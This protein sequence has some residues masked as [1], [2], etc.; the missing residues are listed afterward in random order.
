MESNR[1]FAIVSV[2]VVSVVLAVLG[3][4]ATYVSQTGMANISAEVKYQV[5]EKNAN[6]GLM[7]A[8]KELID[9]TLNCGDTKTYSTDKGSVRVVT[10]SGGNSCFVWAEGR[11]SGGRVVKV[12]II[13]LGGGS[14]FGALSFVNFEGSTMKLRNGSVIT[15]NGFECSALTYVD[16]G[17]VCDDINDYT[18]CGSQPSW[19]GCIDGDVY[20][21]DNIDPDKLFLKMALDEI[22]ADIKNR[23]EKKFNEVKDSIPTKPVVSDTNCV[24]ENVSSCKIKWDQENVIECGGVT[25][26]TSQCPDGIVIR[27]NSVSLD[28]WKGQIYAPIIIEADR[29]EKIRLG[30]TSIRGS[31]FI[32][33]TSLDCGGNDCTIIEMNNTSSLTG[34]VV[35]KADRM[36]EYLKLANESKIDGNI[37]IDLDPTITGDENEVEIK[38]SNNSQITGNV[39]FNGYEFEID[40]ANDTSVGGDIVAKGSHEVEIEMS[41]NSSIKGTIYAYGIDEFELDASNATSIGGKGNIMITDKEFELEINNNTTQDVGILA[42]VG[43]NLSESEAE[44]E[45]T[46]KAF[47]RGFILFG[48]MEELKLPNESMIEGVILGYNLT[49]ELKLSNSANIKGML[50]VL[51]E[52]GNID[53]SNKTEIVGLVY[54]K[55]L[56]KVDMTNEAN[57]K[58]NIDLINKLISDFNLADYFKTLKCEGQKMKVVE[59]FKMKVY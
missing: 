42:W 36:R 11:Y 32:E 41:N 13:G 55:L 6:Y 29:V 1:G 22:K 16:C 50:L 18:G 56:D 53:M 27:G 44:I 4:T 48:N 39:F 34:D 28:F 15:N 19:K 20:N 5:A 59:M 31:M 12:N 51:N 58:L 14:E 23:F 25:L 7:L 49:D 30:E 17:S 10:K 46:N 21:P 35:I 47:F 54:A 3:A 43:D 45:I 26:D 52:L 57:I 24:L 33:A 37:Y 9:K 38:L 40:L 2:L 8:T